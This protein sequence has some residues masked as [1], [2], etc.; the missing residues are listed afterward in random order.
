VVG[1]LLD[2]RLLAARYMRR[3]RVVSESER[4]RESEG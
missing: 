1:D 2:N 4:E 3:V